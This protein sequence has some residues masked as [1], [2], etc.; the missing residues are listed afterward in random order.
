MTENKKINI[1]DVGYGLSL[2]RSYCQYL[3]LTC[4]SDLTKQ[5]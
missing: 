5:N 3:Q 4:D 2:V 1:P